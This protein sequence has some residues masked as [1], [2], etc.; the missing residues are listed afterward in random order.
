MKRRSEIICTWGGIVF[1]VLFFVGFVL[2]A[3]F[4]PPL[5]PNDSAARTAEI[6]RDNTNGIRIGLALCYFGTMAF[7]AFGAGI[8]GQTRRIKGVASTL[9]ILQTA[10]FAAASLLLILPITMWFAAAFRPDTQPA[11]NIQIFNDFGW[12]SFIAG[13]PPF[14]VWIAATGCAILSDSRANPLFPRWSGYFSLLMAFIQAAPPVLLVFF[15]TGPF[16]WN[17]VLSFWIP[18]TDFFVWFLVITAL[19]LKAIDRK[20][21]DEEPAAPAASFEAAGGGASRA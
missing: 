12:I 15:K 6:Y 13:F 16:A 1:A 4:L 5:S 7:L 11:E 3:R 14:V 2:F 21:E 19:T 10:A 9:T 17:G 8:T 18:L 20:Y